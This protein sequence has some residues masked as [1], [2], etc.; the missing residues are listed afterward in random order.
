MTFA[1]I[2]AGMGVGNG[3]HVHLGLIDRE[4]RP[5]M[6]DPAGPGGLSP[7]AGSF[8]AGILRHLPALV[9]FTAA[10]TVSYQR[11]VPHRWS[12]A[13]NNLGCRDREAAVR[14]CPVREGEDVATQYHVEYRA[15]DAV[16]SP[17]LVLAM[18][19]L[20]GTQ[21]LREGLPTP[22]RPRAIWRCSTRPL[23]QGV[24]RLPTSL[25]A[26]LAALEAD[27]TV[28]GWL[29]PLLLDCYRKHKQGEIAALADL[30]EA[31]QA[32]RYAEAY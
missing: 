14:I 8:V 29:P 26:A 19:V 21:G 12:A 25:P 15:A 18:L 30:S 7:T 13:F 24:R 2:V 9:A 5:V 4:G 1:P 27:A 28:K 3:V 6:H 10:S 11:L 20:A 31:E 23:G 22:G 32:K 17:Y 16:A